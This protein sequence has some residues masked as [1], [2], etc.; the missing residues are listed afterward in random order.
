ML[1]LATGWSL[2]DNCL[3]SNP[4]GAEGR[5]ATPNPRVTVLDY[6]GGEGSFCEP[7]VASAEDGRHFVLHNMYL[8]SIGRDDGRYEAVHRKIEYDTQEELEEAF[9][10]IKRSVR[11]PL[12]FAGWVETD[13]SL[14]FDIPIEEFQEALSRAL[15][16]PWDQRLPL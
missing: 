12:S 1:L 14:G 9:R 11:I 3:M 2:N 13:S 5:E 16:T 6:I 10:E 8:S 4:L 15:E 7:L